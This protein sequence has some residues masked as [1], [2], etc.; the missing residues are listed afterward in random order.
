MHTNEPGREPTEPT[1]PT[2]AELELV[3]DLYRAARRLAG[4]KTLADVQAVIDAANEVPWSAMKRLSGQRPMPDTTAPDEQDATLVKLIDLLTRTANAVKG[5]PGEMKQHGWADLPE[6]CT[7]LTARVAELEAELARYR[8]AITWA[9]GTNGE[10]EPNIIGR[11]F[12]WRTEL[13]NRAGITWDGEKWIAAPRK[14]A[15]Q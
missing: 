1:E 5:Q 11:P 4:N 6:L 7:A 8:D 14:G 12:W 9:L 10:F 3:L 13:H 2:D 15:D